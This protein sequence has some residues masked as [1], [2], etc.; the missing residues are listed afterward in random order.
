MTPLKQLLADRITDHL[1]DDVM[2]NQD[3]FNELSQLPFMERRNK[4]LELIQEYQ[5]QRFAHLIEEDLVE[6]L[7]ETVKEY[8]RNRA[9]RDI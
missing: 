3:Q 1:D 9:E 7:I 4:F 6:I 2:L 8:T 5:E